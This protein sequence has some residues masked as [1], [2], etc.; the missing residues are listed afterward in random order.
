MYRDAKTGLL[1]TNGRWRTHLFAPAVPVS[2][3]STPVD[4]FRIVAL[5]WFV[6]GIF[7]AWPL[8]QNES[9]AQQSDTSLAPQSANINTY[10]EM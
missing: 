10:L 8:V 4:C 7:L 9:L 6:Q 3:P 1:R 5:M 2:L